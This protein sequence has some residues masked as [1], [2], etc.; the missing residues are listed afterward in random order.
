MLKECAGLIIS[1]FFFLA[2]V[3]TFHILLWG[4]IFHGVFNYQLNWG[5]LA[6]V[7]AALFIISITIF[8]ATEPS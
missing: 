3:I 5:L 1:G 2:S 7:A 4:Y 8:G 6:E